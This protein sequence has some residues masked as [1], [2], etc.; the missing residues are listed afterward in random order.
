LYEF[1]SRIDRFVVLVIAVLDP[2]NH[3]VTL[4]SAGHRA[5]LLLGA[6]SVLEDPMPKE[7]AGLP[8]GISEGYIYKSCQIRLR[9]GDTLLLFNSGIAAILNSRNNALGM[10]GVRR[11]FQVGGVAPP[12]TLGESFLQ[13]V[14]EHARGR[15]LHTDLAFACFGRTF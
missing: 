6:D 4:M 2:V 15:D 3:T 13:S 7:I 9:P 12:S 14:L 11:A 8:L 10:M 1:A 5:P